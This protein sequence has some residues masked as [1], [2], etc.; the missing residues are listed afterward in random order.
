MKK[1]G[2]Q[3]KKEV[4]GIPGMIIMRT[5]SGDSYVSGIEKNSRTPKTKIRIDNYIKY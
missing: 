3:P 1:H 2:I 4:K 5:I